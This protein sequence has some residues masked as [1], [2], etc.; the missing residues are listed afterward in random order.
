MNNVDNDNNNLNFNMDYNSND[1]INNS[2]ISNNMIDDKQLNDGLL[3]NSNDVLNNIK[4]NDDIVAYFSDVKKKNFPVWI[5][6]LILLLIVFFGGLYY[7]LIIDTPKNIF[8]VFLNNKLYNIKIADYEK[9]NIDFDVNTKFISS[10]DVF[11]DMF[12]VINNITVKG[13]VG[14]DLIN[15]LFFV[16]LEP[17]YESKKLLSMNAYYEDNNI[18]LESNDIYDK[19]LKTEVPDEVV[20]TINE[21]LKN[22]S[23]DEVDIIMNSVRNALSDVLNNIK[24]EKEYV[25]LEKKYVKKVSIYIEPQTLV[26]FYK[27]LVN[28]EDFLSS[29]AKLTGESQSD[30]KESI[31]YEIET[32]EEYIN[33]D[34]CEPLKISL[35]LSSLINKFYR[36]EFISDDGMMTLDKKDEL[37]SYRL[38]DEDNI[39]QF[40]GDFS[41][42]ENKKNN[43]TFLYTI[44][45]IEEK[46]SMEYRINY[47]IE[48]NKDI[49]KISIVDAVDI[50]ELGFDELGQIMTNVTENENMSKFIEDIN[51][52]Y[53]DLWIEEQ[54]SY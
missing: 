29:C 32:Y 1:G 54:V 31:E 2:N 47:T 34:D 52:C 19:V 35:Y 15:K 12:D 45:F 22:D 3:N 42:V 49:K 23:R 5:I 8:G 37:F 39:I 4:Q 43:Y 36:L 30:L 44:D 18:Y 24:F 26:D 11:K 40:E 21:L 50:Y 9:I 38:Y 17:M 51:S 41:F 7:F 46:I 14:E 28:D 48:Y 6:F 10:D 20:N 16:N 13:S 27:S 25:K 33:D 53:S